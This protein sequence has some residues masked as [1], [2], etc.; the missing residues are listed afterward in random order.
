MNYRES[1]FKGEDSS[2]ELY[3][4]LQKDSQITLFHIVHGLQ[5][6]SWVIHGIFNIDSN[7][8]SRSL[9]WNRIFEERVDTYFV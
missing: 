3:E 1:E 5:H 7:D 4:I 9:R 2:P 6:G 8:I